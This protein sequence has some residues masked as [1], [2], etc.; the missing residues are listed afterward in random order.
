MRDLILNCREVDE[1]WDHPPEEA[2]ARKH[3][4]RDSTGRC[5]VDKDSWFTYA[6]IPGTLH[7]GLR[8]TDGH[9]EII[10]SSGMLGTDCA[11]G[12]N[13]I[14]QPIRPPRWNL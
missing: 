10:A 6:C 2:G 11:K 4:Y 14:S 13:I 5:S 1:E 8:P 3:C 9:F 7:Y 12:A